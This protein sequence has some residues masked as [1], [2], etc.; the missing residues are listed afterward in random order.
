MTDQHVR[1]MVTTP[2]GELT[3]QHYFVRERC[4]PRVLSLRF[5][6]ADAAR[7][8]PGFERALHDLTLSAIIVCPSNPFLS[9]DPIL[10]VPGISETLRAAA[11][12]VAVSPIVG[13]QAL[14]GPAAKML[15]E[16]GLEV[17]A[18]AVAKY[19]AN[20]ALLHGFVLDHRDADLHRPIEDLGVRVL[21]TDT[22]MKSTGD[23]QRLALQVLAFAATL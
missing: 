12:I 8:S 21:V 4:M 6:G 17:S 18:L 2:L 9:V 22:V 23:K 1:T 14:K 15:A 20:R 7:P 11:P 19:Y 16:L 3:F 10:A 13:G 5:D